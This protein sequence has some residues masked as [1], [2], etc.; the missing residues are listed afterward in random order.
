MTVHYTRIKQHILLDQIHA[1]TASKGHSPNFRSRHLPTYAVWQRFCAT[2]QEILQLNAEIAAYNRF[3]CPYITVYFIGHITMTVF[4]VY[5]F[6]KG[7]A[8]AFELG[9][10]SFFVFY[11]VD[12]F[13]LMILITYECSMIVYNYVEIYKV[14]YRKVSP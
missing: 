10:R 7:G 11:A 8:A 4:L 5:G 3:W 14:S 1:L 9:E 2:N 13:L 12:C 6:I